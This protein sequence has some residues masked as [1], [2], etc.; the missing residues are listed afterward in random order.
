MEKDN[1]STVDDY[2][3]DYVD[4]H[5]YAIGLIGEGL[6][7]VGSDAS[8]GHGR[9][10]DFMAW[11]NKDKG[12]ARQLTPW[13]TQKMVKPLG[14]LANRRELVKAMARKG[15]GRTG[16]VSWKRYLDSDYPS[17]VNHRH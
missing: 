5:D 3:D 13:R 16:Y 9:P 1:D 11:C 15:W 7:S 10:S 4:A 8:E 17:S 6:V 2:V 12:Y 14:R